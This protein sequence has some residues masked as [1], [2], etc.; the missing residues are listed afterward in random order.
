M[1]PDDGRSAATDAPTATAP[2]PERVVLLDEDATPIGTALKS[3]VHTERTPLHLAFSCFVVSE[4]GL[5]VTR[6]ALSKRTWPGV[7][8]NAVCGHPGPGEAM[9]DAVHRRAGQELGLQIDEPRLVL[10]T[11]RYRSVDLSGIVENE[12]CPVFVAHAAPD[13]RLAPDP[14]EVA[15]ATW[16]TWEH[17]ERAV[18]AAPYAF[19]P[20][21]ALELPELLAAGVAD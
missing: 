15:E 16:T 7:W 12:V 1:M 10:P 21:L 4:R 9:P 3:E 2:V 5:L 19:S 18:A 11:F 6:R 20:W 17:L 13:A 14:A 8:T